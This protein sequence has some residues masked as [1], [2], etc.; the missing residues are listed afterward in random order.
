M[1]FFDGIGGFYELNPFPGCNQLVV[2]NHSWLS[3]KHRGK[4][5]GTKIHIQRLAQIRILGYDYALCTVRADNAPQV[6][7]LEKCGWKLLDAFTNRETGNVVK[8][9]GI[10]IGEGEG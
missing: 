1:R 4:G 2:S 8:L 3:P 10:R 5:L 9:Y 7:I 6:R